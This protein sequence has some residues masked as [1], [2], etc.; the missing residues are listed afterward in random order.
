[1][2]NSFCYK[3]K[4]FVNCKS[5]CLPNLTTNA[6][7]KLVIVG[8]FASEEDDK[9]GAIFS[10]SA[11]K[12]F[13]QQLEKF[14]MSYYLTNI[15]KC[16]PY[17]LSEKEVRG[18]ITVVKTPSKPTLTHQKSCLP[19]FYKF[20]DEIKP[21]VIITIGSFATN[22]ILNLG[23]SIDKSRGHSYYHPEL[24]AHV[25]P[26]YDLDIL[27]EDTMYI[28]HLH[29]DL[30]KAKTLV[31]TRG[32]KKTKS[33]PTSLKDPIEIKEFIQSL[34]TA[35]K[36]AYDLETTGL[37]P[38]VDR[39]TDISFCKESG[40]GVHIRWKDVLPYLS[41]LEKVLTNENILHYGQ[42]LKF[43][44]KFL[45][46]AGIKT[47]NR[48]FDTMLGYHTL[49]MTHEGA[50]GGL[51]KLDRLSWL[52]THQGNYK[53]IL[54][55]WGGIGNYQEAEKDENGQIIEKPQKEK[56]AKIKAEVPAPK[57]VA[58]LPIYQN[59]DMFN[60][61]NYEDELEELLSHEE[62]ETNDSNYACRA[63]YDYQVGNPLITALMNR[64]SVRT[65]AANKDTGF[66]EK[67]PKVSSDFVINE[68]EDALLHTYEHMVSKRKLAQLESLQLTPLEYYSAMDADVTFQVA[69]AIMP[70][71]EKDY[72]QLYWDLILPL[73]R[74]IT[75][76]EEHGILLDVEYVKTII[77]K[78]EASMLDSQKKI[79]QIYGKEFNIS[80]GDDMR[81]VMYTD[82]KIKE[83]PKYMTKGGKG[84]AK[85][86]AS[87][88]QFALEHFAK[89][90][91]KHKDFFTNVLEYRKIEKENSTYFKGF[92]D[93]VD[94]VSGRIHGSYLQT[95]TATGRLSCISEGTKIS[96]VGEDKNIEDVRVGD[97]VYCYDKDGI[98]RISKVTNTFDN[99]VQ[100]C[101][102]IGWQSSGNGKTGELI[103]TP[104][105][106]IFTKR[107]GWVE[108]KD[109]KRYDKVY[110]LKKAYNRYENGVTLYGTNSFMEEE[111][112]V[113]KTEY[114]KAPS[115]YHIHHKD[116]NRMNNRISNLQI[117]TATEH[118]SYHGKK[119][120]AEGKAVYA[121]LPHCRKVPSRGSKN[122]GYITC[123]KDGLIQ[124]LRDAK[125][126]YTKVPMDFSTFVL[127]CKVHNVDYKA[128]ATEYSR[129][130]LHITKEVLQDAIM[131]RKNYIEENIH[132]KDPLWQ[133][134]YDL[135]ITPNK[136]RKLL[137]YYD[138]SINHAVT[139]ISDFG[140][141]HV[142]DLE[143]EEHHNFIAN[144]LCVHNCLKPNLQN[145][146]RVSYVRNMIIPS[147]GCKLVGADL[148]Q[149]ELRILAMVSNDSAMKAAFASGFDFHSATACAMFNLSIASFDEKNDPKHKEL[150]GI[151][152]TINFGI[153]Y[154]RGAKSIA[155]QVGCSL[156]EA[157]E[158]MSKFFKSYP[159]VKQWIGDTIATARRVGYVETVHGRRRYL[160]FIN[161]MDAAKR[162][163]AENQAIN[164]PI[165]GTAS[166]CACYG[167][168]R[169]TE[170]AINQGYKARPC[171]IIHDEI[172]M[173]TPDEEVDVFEKQLPIAMTQNIPLITI[174]L[175]ADA[176]I[177]SRWEK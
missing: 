122:K 50:S 38:R 104:D 17:K 171:M 60:R 80:S 123:T 102:K 81:R 125:G 18:E 145:I 33:T 89:T 85:K 10:S 126:K 150:R 98:L 6:N 97:L 91:P 83:D 168:I 133:L 61:E 28:K 22:T 161:S 149:A 148:S 64:V 84:G 8:A 77:E 131:K 130:G 52:F 79:Y 36:I 29:E 129:T 65:P 108:A 49:T 53:S 40:K 96:C 165:Q 25:I 153:A 70:L 173:D 164:T 124:M 127:K 170:F 135:K 93:L 19:H 30:K 138:V 27:K 141:C 114:F 2:Q 167:L 162:N 51:Y 1:M 100:E 5:P 87:V 107:K 71:V 68:E 134:Q 86:Q 151:S 128:I 121:H 156:Q 11:S 177:L 9:H 140:K 166:D 155:E 175:V 57:P 103:C 58:R 24:N 13:L 157:E 44:R 14:G 137:K 154:G 66:R 76:M 115:N 82:L 74:A 101:I 3:C 139:K 37:N 143:V 39:I 20:I 132:L 34:A 32:F 41:D 163:H 73:N 12:L 92:L 48:Y 116:E 45:A 31:D 63:E 46:H 142:Y 158:F 95:T 35:E 146:P 176:S 4:L 120:V 136:V 16:T 67:K 59:V 113:I 159:N 72:S 21:K 106:R 160:P 99:G 7:S 23:L 172:Q 119:R 147:P 152:K 47:H 43:D 90:Y 144:E 174:P 117:L 109:L 15:V 78:N 56:K 112:R 105:H 110:H 94:P 169:I 55:Q 88:D 42:N 111:H 62:E 26:V 69:E 75:V 118:T 54:E